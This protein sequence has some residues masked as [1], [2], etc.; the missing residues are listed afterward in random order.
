[1]EGSSQ[2][3][4]IAAILKEEPPALTS[5]QPL[6]PP[7]LERSV[8][9]CLAKDPARRWQTAADLRDE[10]TWIA[11]SASP[12]PIVRKAGRERAAWIL[13]AL[14]LGPSLY[15]AGSRTATRVAG[16]LARFM[17]DPPEKTILSGPSNISA[18]A[19]QIVLSP[20]GRHIAFTA[21]TAESR[22]MLW[23]RTLD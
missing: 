14:I 5:F 6:T 21:S 11:T 22:P 23:V 19:P 3:S 8:R 15:L 4:L 17:I 16:Q 9:K 10:L 18:P 12:A 20:D 7:A 1:F 13:P 2:A